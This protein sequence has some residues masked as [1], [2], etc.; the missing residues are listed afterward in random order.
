MIKV[1]RLNHSELVVNAEM[2]EFIEAAPDTIIS[3]VSGKKV[4]VSESV[5]MVI[6]RIVQYKRNCGRPL[7]GGGQ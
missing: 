6:D 1:T 2:I 3:L 7:V 4:M 5:D